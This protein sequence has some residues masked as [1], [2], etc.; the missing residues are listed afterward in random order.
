[1]FDITAEKKAG[2]AE[3]NGTFVHI[4]GLDESPLFFTDGEEEKPV[5]IIVAGA[6]SRRYREIEG[7]QRKRKLRPRDLTGERAMEDS[8]ERAAHCTISWQGFSADGV[9]VPFSRE[10]AKT[11]YR[12]CPWVLEQVAEAMQEHSRFFKK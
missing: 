3:D 4:H 5:G 10:N 6:H 7:I 1:M 2:E 9:V 12:E 11:L 8:L